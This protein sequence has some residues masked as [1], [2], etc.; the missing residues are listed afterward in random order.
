VVVRKRATGVRRSSVTLAIGA[1]S[2]A[3]LIGHVSKKIRIENRQ[4][5]EAV[6]SECYRTVTKCFGRLL[7]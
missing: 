4:R 6:S 3:G 1:L 7:S 2:R 5:L